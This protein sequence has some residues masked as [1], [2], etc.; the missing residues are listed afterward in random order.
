M[1]YIAI[2]QNSQKVKNESAKSQR[3]QKNYGVK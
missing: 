1:Y 2:G 3:I